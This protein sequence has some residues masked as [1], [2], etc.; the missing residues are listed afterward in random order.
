MN[1]VLSIINL[2]LQNQ[3]ALLT[4]QSTREPFTNET[5]FE[6]EEVDEAEEMEENIDTIETTTDSLPSV[7]QQYTLLDIIRS[8]ILLRN[9]FILWFAWYVKRPSHVL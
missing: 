3:D 5:N 1:K 6:L 4:T 7:A 2:Q 8:G 9:S